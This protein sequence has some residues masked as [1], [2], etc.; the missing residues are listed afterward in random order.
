MLSIKIKH[1][2]F[3]GV[4]RVGCGI[5]LTKFVSIGAVVTA[6]PS[7]PDWNARPW[8]CCS[9]PAGLAMPPVFILTLG[10]QEE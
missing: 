6:V 10:P 7:V 1:K 8:L 4:S 2:T 3:M 9:A 5:W